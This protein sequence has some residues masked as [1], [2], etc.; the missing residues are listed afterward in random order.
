MGTQ[1]PWSPLTQA[2]IKKDA[3]IL[4]PWEHSLSKYGNFGPGSWNPGTNDRSY[5]W[6]TWDHIALSEYFTLLINTF[7]QYSY[8]YCVFVIYLYFRYKDYLL[9]HNK[10]PTQFFPMWVLSKNVTQGNSCC[11]SRRIFMIGI[12]LFFSLKDISSLTKCI[13]FFEARLIIWIL[14]TL[15]NH[16]FSSKVSGYY[17]Y[18][19]DKNM[20]VS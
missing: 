17:L 9:M 5:V 6:Q 20:R 4:G 19:K 15:K 2:N 7:H 18:Y 1:W 11:S 3:G 10:L 14:M 16:T 12:Y 13:Q 8:K